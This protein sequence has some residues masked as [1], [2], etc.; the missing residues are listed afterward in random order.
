MESSAAVNILL[1]DDHPEN[2]VA[3]E[4]ILSG[5][6]GNLVKATSG[7][8]ALRCLLHQDFAVILLDVQ[9]PGMDGFETATLIR[10]RQRSRQIPIIFLTAFSSNDSLIF[11]GYS[12][13]AVDYL[14]KPIDPQI[15]TS[16]VTV[17][18]D[19]FRK[20]AA[21]K[22]QTSQLQAINAQL[23]ESQERLQDFLDNANDLIQIISVQGQFLYVNRI[24]QQQLGYAASETDQLSSLDIIHPEGRQAFEMA[25]QTVQHQSQSYRLETIFMARD[26][27]EIAVEGNLSCRFEGG[28]PI[29][30]RCL[31]HDITERKQA[32]AA[33]TQFMQEQ[34]A[35]QQAE[36][37]NRM[38]DEFLATLSHEL[39][40]PLNSILGWAKL[41]RT[42]SF[43]EA[44]T[45]R[46][47]ET[48]ERNAQ[49]QAQLIED[50][51]DV[52]RIVTGKLNLTLHPVNLIPI[53]EAVLDGVRP[54]A[55]AKSLTLDYSLD[56]TWHV[57]PGVGNE[58]S[59]PLCLVKGDPHRLQQ[60]IWNLLSNAIKFTP[61]GGCV[62]V[63]LERREEGEGGD[64]EGRG[65]GG[66]R[67]DF[68][69][70]SAWV[71]MIVIDTGIGISPD[72][73][74]YVFDRFR[75][76]DATTTRSHS[77]LGLGL[78]IVKQLVTLHGGQVEAASAGPD[79]GTTFTVS[80]PL[81]V[82]IPADLE[83]ALT[84][85]KVEAASSCPR[86]ND[87]RVLVVDDE[88]DARELLVMALE[89]FGAQVKAAASAAMALSIL[90]QQPPDLLISDVGM[91]EEDGY[92]LIRQLRSRS[93][94][95]GGDVPAIALTAYAAGED[96]ARLLA[97]GFQAHLTKPFE[98]EQL[99]QVVADLTGKVAE[100]SV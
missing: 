100:A 57:P 20:T 77:G 11:K 74:P 94:E 13:G 58:A 75:Q 66:D 72:F 67:R 1:V 7:E 47:L 21:I 4:A 17:F 5:L 98:P 24:W 23:Q 25:C 69:S 78:A 35:R 34:A 45:H 84:A 59:Q 12:L 95:T 36:V 81:V 6:G 38:K 55:E 9:M 8:E 70:G 42:R 29:A 18:V 44:T 90:E 91:P 63:R 33:R 53:L 3:L 71:Q 19:L 56:E 88:P 30:I 26:G 97:A 28:K 68:E 96:S 39:R 62:N 76:A 51:L 50:M 31:F 46:A 16:K 54:A 92:A 37:A 32:E 10:T 52:S 86:L 2:L 14:L 15:L 27:R 83:P 43:D 64:A 89:Q 80:L 79:Q 73:L 82:K 41:L 60:V 85:N 40:T 49:A 61:D 87:L 99:A 93:P 22:Q 48:I 65:D